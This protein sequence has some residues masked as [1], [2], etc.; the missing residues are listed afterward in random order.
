[1]RDLEEAHRWYQRSA[2][3]GCPEGCLGYALSL[4]PR[5]SDEAGRH[6]VAENLRHAAEAELPTAIYL[7]AVL[8]EQGVGVAR[9]PVIAARLYGHAA[10]RGQ[11]A[12]QLR[13]GLALM[14]GRDVEQD[15]VLGESWLRRA[16]LAGDPDAA[17]IWA[18]KLY[19][20]SWRTPMPRNP[21]LKTPKG[22]VPSDWMRR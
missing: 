16:A 19:A 14:E 20:S 22:A 11:R 13:W 17:R 1:M 6:E 3:S 9:D 15:L 21:S 12:A 8:T 10:E 5:T 4:A 7:L 2:A 18:E